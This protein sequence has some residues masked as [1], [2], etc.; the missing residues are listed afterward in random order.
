MPRPDGLT[1]PVARY[2]IGIFD[3][4]SARFGNGLYFTVNRPGYA[5]NV[6]LGILDKIADRIVSVIIDAL[7]IK[8]GTK[9]CSVMFISLFLIQKCIF[10]SRI[11]LFCI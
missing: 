3:C 2:I 11:I 4:R 7:I 9:G 8:R 1:D 6:L 5:G 10:F